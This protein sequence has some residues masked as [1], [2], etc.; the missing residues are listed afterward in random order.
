MV[1]RGGRLLVDNATMVVDTLGDRD[2]AALGID[3][4]V[5]QEM[6][7]TREG[8]MTTASL[9]MGNA[10]DVR[11]SAGSLDLRQNAVISSQAFAAGAPGATAVEVGTLTLTQGGR[12]GHFAPTLDLERGI[13]VFAGQG[14]AV[15]VMAAGAVTITGGGLD[16]FLAGGIPSGLYSQT[17]GGADAGTLTLTAPTVRLDG[18]LITTLTASAGDAGD[19]VAS[20][21][22]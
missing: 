10:G 9:G 17:G 13:V 14:G 11:V 15:S 1:I 19:I 7:V 18:G 20:V 5:A 4:E 16:E 12:I 2:G 22:L 21:R 3:I 8:A 6:V